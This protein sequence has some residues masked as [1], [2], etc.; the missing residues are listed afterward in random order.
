M[1]LYQQLILFMLAAT[2]LPLAVVG[3]LLLRGAEAEI[4]R[5]ITSEQQARATGASE[6]VATYLLGAV[7]SIARSAESF[8]WGRASDEERLGGLKLLYRQSEAVSA[9]ALL[10][11]EGKL[12]SPPVFTE[13]GMGS[14]PPFSY[15]GLS[16]L[17][18]AIPL[19]N[20]SGGGKGQ[21]AVSSAYPHSKGQMA[22]LA[23]AV[24]L[25]PAGQSPFA[26]AE[27]G[28]GALDGV[29]A[30]RASLESGR[31]DLVDEDGRVIASS[32]PGPLLQPLP[33][34]L[35]APVKAGLTDDAPHSFTVTL[36]E[37]Y[38]VSARPVRGQL[39][40]YTVVSVPERV[41][42]Q[43]VRA[44]RR[45][46]L[47]SVGAAL[48]VL[49]LLGGAFTRSMNRRIGAV[50]EGAEQFSHGDLSARIL[51]TG[52]DELAD[53]SETFNRMGGELEGARAKL[54]R[55][56]DELRQR[57]EEATQELKDAQAQLLESQKMAAIGQLGAGVAHEINNPLAGIL[58]NTQLLMLDRPETD[59]DFD[60]LR[61][62]EQMAKRCKD[63]TQ[64]LLRFSQARD[65][66][67]LRPMDL[68]AVVRDAFSLSDNQ[69]K[70]EGIAVVVKLQPGALMV[71][72]DPGHLSQVVLAMMQ[73]ARTAMM[74]SQVKELKIATRAEGQN[75]VLEITDTGKGIAPEHLPR[76][77]D[78]FFTT[79]DVWTN[80][81][82]GLSVAYRV[83]TE[84]QGKIDVATEV[85]KGSTF[86]VRIPRLPAA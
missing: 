67:Q 78:P 76:I 62:I 71:Q 23:V 86:T 72:G 10:D 73:N 63:I 16:Q 41:A 24:K 64:N 17:Q 39:R 30:S 49:L 69:T 36:A 27:L 83:I 70:G 59:P 8:D 5:R 4:S 12:L 82:L 15:P 56:N 9:V 28:L 50:V 77:F 45:T 52:S 46:V 25:Q 42:L 3:F 21:A 11:S 48:A 51:V 19:G 60:T 33:A 80:V 31:I 74:K 61:K 57:V 26:V 20:L 68:N 13:D 85:G 2:V 38:L 54:M 1:K 34:T 40:L 37:P 35:W 58:G 32:E 66:G 75:A 55:W 47:L 6:S 79:K 43:P 65:K 14:H 44:M 53:L 7:E 18:K 84:H 29:L 22:A 81:G